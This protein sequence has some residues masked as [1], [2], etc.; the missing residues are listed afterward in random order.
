MLLNLIEREF[1][2]VLR[3]WKEKFDIVWFKLRLKVVVIVVVSLRVFG[4][5]VIVI[6][7][8]DVLF[9]FN[10]LIMVCL[11]WGLVIIGY[12]RGEM[13][14]CMKIVMIKIFLLKVVKL[15]VFILRW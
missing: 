3:L 8:I 13:L 1:S 12:C 10:F 6:L 9:M 7:E 2:V 5:Y 11:I 14:V 4:R 15:K